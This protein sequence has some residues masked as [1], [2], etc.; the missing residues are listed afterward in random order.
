MRLMHSI[1]LCKLLQ[2]ADDARAE[3]VQIH[4]N[5]QT[6]LDK[7]V[8]PLL[9]P[10]KPPSESADTT[11]DVDVPTSTR[12]AP[13]PKRTKTP[14]PKTLQVRVLHLYIPSAL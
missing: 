6:H 12:P 11:T 14:D 4:F 9:P 5:T 3:R 8:Q 10:S 2:N 1:V 7:L 13:T